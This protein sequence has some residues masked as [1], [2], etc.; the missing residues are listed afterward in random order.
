MQEKSGRSDSVVTEKKEDTV[1]QK[2]SNEN[3]EY[4][5]QLESGKS[6]KGEGPFVVNA[7]QL[8]ADARDEVMKLLNTHYRLSQER[9]QQSEK[10]AQQI[11]PEFKQD[12]LLEDEPQLASED[13]TFDPEL[14]SGIA[15]LLTRMAV[16]DED[17][18]QYLDLAELPAELREP[19][20]S[21]LMRQQQDEEQMQLDDL[22]KE[23]IKVEAEENNKPSVPVSPTLIKQH[24][25]Q[26]GGLLGSLIGGA[27][28][29]YPGIQLK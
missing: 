18:N 28:G 24:G 27:V 13:E 19:V 25:S 14:A 11:Q 10:K 26:V 15:E 6:I 17:G 9:K 22:V 29:G 1:D 12:D 5:A 3:D 7:E 2:K 20:S 16:E 21:Y 4:K 23:Q 8:P